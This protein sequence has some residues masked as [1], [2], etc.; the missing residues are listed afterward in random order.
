MGKRYRITSRIIGIVAAELLLEMG[1]MVLFFLQ[2]RLTVKSET[3][4]SYRNLAGQII[5]QFCATKQ[6]VE[7]I[8]LGLSYRDMVQDY[9]SEESKRKKFQM[10]PYLRENLEY[11]ISANGD[12]VNIRILNAAGECVASGS[13]SVFPDMFRMERSALALMEEKERGGRFTEIYYYRPDDMPYFAY[14][15][16]VYASD[17]KRGIAA[18]IGAC[19]VI[20]SLESLQRSIE[21]VPVQDGASFLLLDSGNR[22]LASSD[23][24]QAGTVLQD[25][26][27]IGPVPAEENEVVYRRR[28]GL[29]QFILVS[30]EGLTLL[31]SIPDAVLTSCIPAILQI[32]LCVIL[33]ASV[34]IAI[35]TAT[36]LRNI[37]H[38]ITVMVEEMR[39]VPPREEQHR[40]SIVANNEI[41]MIS[42]EINSMLERME[43]L[44]DDRIRAAKE[45]AEARLLQNQAE[46][47]FLRS[48]I[49]P[50]FLY[51]SLECIRGMALACH[52]EEIESMTISLSRLYRYA[53]SFN[54]MV[55]LKEEL[56][57]V[58][59]Y[60][61]IMSLRF[62]KNYTLLVEVPEPL[63]GVQVMPMLLQP[64]VE[65]AFKHG[66]KGRRGSQIK[67]AARE[68]DG[69][70]R[71]SVSDDGRG[72][73]PRL[74]EQLN[75][76]LCGETED[77]LPDREDTGEASRSSVGLW[78]IQKRIRMQYGRDCG[79]K[80]EANAEGGL[81][82]TATIRKL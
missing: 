14:L 23:G 49:N 45:L 19:C 70:L 41:G 22:I 63:P 76:T 5:E 9:L 37:T 42:A 53:L 43:A 71:L 2:Y 60:C 15:L 69:F 18:P 34:V 79:L 27:D 47:S 55:S 81:T 44:N 52:A 7:D 8:A 66:F 25:M 58:M 36:L 46:L 78:N 72:M 62:R 13:N 28:G 39:K 33:A 6:E 77:A 16:P 3:E 68:E 56:R 20:C 29:S 64:I 21:I 31:Y 11:V 1:M 82:V 50:H 40:L 4:K 57:C 65:N 26:A 48:Q 17:E 67:V 75:E 24:I 74:L 61:N 80:V 73:E 51:N 35:V 10:L 38:P 30:E 32:L 54:A 12:I 59:E